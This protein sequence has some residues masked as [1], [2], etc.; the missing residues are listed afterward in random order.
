MR[1][2]SVAG[3]LAALLDL[4]GSVEL[5]S[6]VAGIDK[7]PRSA[8]EPRAGARLEAEVREVMAVALGD[9]RRAFA[10]LRSPARVPVAGELDEAL[11]DEGEGAIGARLWAPLGDTLSRCVD[12]VRA[13]ARELRA[14]L[15]GDVRALGAAAAR[16]EAIDAALAGPRDRAL[17]RR[18]A[19]LSRAVEAIFRDELRAAIRAGQRAAGWLGPEGCYGRALALAERVAID[20]GRHE[21]SRIDALIEAAGEAH[22]E[23]IAP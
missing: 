9:V 1:T 11:G 4:R 12:G 5:A 3:E 23:A 13:R 10:V 20:V 16:L 21:R 6:L 8:G 15:A 7:L 19:A 2:D 14:D 17:G 18:V 22:P